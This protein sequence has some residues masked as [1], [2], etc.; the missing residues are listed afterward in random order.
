MQ[1]LTGSPFRRGRRNTAKKW[2]RIPKKRYRTT[3]NLTEGTNNAK[4]HARKRSS[5]TGHVQKIAQQGHAHKRQG[6]WLN[7]RTEQKTIPKKKRKKKI[8]KGIASSRRRILSG[9]VAAE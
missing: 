3:M 4:Q 5:A 8:Q 6:A 2:W 7:I 9:G 1:K